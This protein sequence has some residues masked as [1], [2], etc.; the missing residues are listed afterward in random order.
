MAKRGTGAGTSR[1]GSKKKHPAD[2][3]EMLEAD[4]R[5]VETLFDDFLKGDAGQQQRI[6]QELFRELEVHSTLEEEL[7]YPALH[8]QGLELISG[9]PDENATNGEVVLSDEEEVGDGVDAEIYSEED[10]EDEAE[11]NETD[12]SEDTITSV[13][14]DHRKVRDQI[15]RLRQIDTSTA[16]FRQNMVELQDM[17]ADHVS[18]EE[19]ELFPEARISLDLAMLGRQMQERKADILSEAA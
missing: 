3:I 14:D 17:V 9:S 4:H 16:E 12:L 10:E 7:F 19:E 13:Y 18:T 1:A 2:A 15:T 8:A 11:E 6:A 5:K